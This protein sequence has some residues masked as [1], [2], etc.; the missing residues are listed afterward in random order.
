MKFVDRTEEIHLLITFTNAT[1][2]ILQNPFN[3]PY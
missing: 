3:K 2:S 1:S